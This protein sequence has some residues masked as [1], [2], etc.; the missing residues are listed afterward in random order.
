MN[1][2][3]LEIEEF[4]WSQLDMKEAR[5]FGSQT[6]EYVLENERSCASN[7]SVDCQS[8][9]LEVQMIISASLWL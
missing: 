8:I 1:Q 6:K 7:D 4:E 3:V 2:K 5:M 9:P